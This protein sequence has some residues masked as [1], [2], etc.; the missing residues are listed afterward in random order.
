MT[1]EVTIAI[2]QTNPTVGDIE[3]NLERIRSFR[4]A[5]AAAGADLVV[6][7]ELVRGRL[8][9]RGPGAQAGAAGRRA[10]P[11]SRRSRRTPRTAAR[12]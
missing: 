7:S 11:R 4:A 10:E 5:A 6:F 8:S 3:G 12:R 2:A 1:A 9:A